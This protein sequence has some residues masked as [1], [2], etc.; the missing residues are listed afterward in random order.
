MSTTDPLDPAALAA[1]AQTITGTAQGAE[2]LVKVTARPQGAI[3]EI[4]V[5]PVLHDGGHEA[6]AAEIMAVIKAAQEAADAEYRQRLQGRFV[7]AMQQR[8]GERA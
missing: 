3:I 6:A 4:A 7:A 5:D 2:G 8:G 1:L